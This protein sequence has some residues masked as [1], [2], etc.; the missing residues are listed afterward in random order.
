[1]AGE[2]LYQDLSS[3]AYLDPQMFPA[4]QLQGLVPVIILLIIAAVV[5]VIISFVFW[6]WMIADCARRKSFRNGDSMM[7]ILL[8]VLAAPIGTTLYY[9]MEVR[10]A[11]KESKLQEPQPSHPSQ[12]NIS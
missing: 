6:I 8:L 3:V 2:E 11:R 7:W 9:F 4:D 10:P 1:M 5:L 12:N